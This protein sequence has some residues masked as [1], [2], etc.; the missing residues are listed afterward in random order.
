[1]V[2]FWSTIGRAACE[3]CSASWNLG[4]NS[5][6]ALG[7]TKTTENLDRVGRSQDLPDEN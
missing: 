5:E 2:K 3:A 6:F 1:M 7:T 4:T